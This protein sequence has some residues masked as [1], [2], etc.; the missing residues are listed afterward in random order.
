M[1]SS[2]P[3]P[4]STTCRQL[5]FL[6]GAGTVTGSK[7]LVATNGHRF[8]LDCGLFQGLKELRE[9][10]RAKPSV[11]PAA[12]DA[13]VLSQAHVH[14]SGYLPLLARQGF[15]GPVYCTPPTADLLR[16]MLLDSARLLE[17]EAEAAN[18]LG[19][20]KHQPA[21]PLYTSS[22]AYVALQR[23]AVRRY[24]EPFAV[25]P[26]VSA[27]FRRSAHVL[28]AATVD[29]RLGAGSPTRLVYSGDLG[30]RGRL[31]LRDLEP[32]PEADVL[33][34]EST[35]GDSTHSPSTSEQLAEVI[36]DAGARSG[37]VIVPCSG[38]GR[39][40]ELLWALQSLEDQ[41]RIPRLALFVDSP[42][43]GDLTEIYRR[44]A[45]EHNPGAG[46]ILD[47]MLTEKGYGVVRTVAESKALN[48]RRGPMIIIAGSGMATGGRVLHH[49]KVRLPDARTTVLLAGHQGAGTRGRMLQEG[50]KQIRI[51]GQWVPVH[52]RVVSIEGLSGH[53]DRDEIVAW[54]RGFA[55]APSMTY[56]VHGE[57][58]AAEGLA[59]AIREQLGWSVR[60]AG[61]EE[62]VALESARSARPERALPIG[63]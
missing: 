28:G 54:L 46:K 22:D 39:A 59:R 4:T 3:T 18:R 58:P 1:R 50:V 29:V 23:I 43:A 25:V 21:S 44:H 14:H 6:G 38:V 49:L 13:V 63:Q 55:R 12:I 16:V 27:V 61:H 48:G 34:L 7:Y 15:R 47:A 37:T 10:N 52:A 31:V 45:E 24:H 19:Y 60:V 17:E 26:G 40:Q 35:Y 30:R 32:V 2:P 51:F 56:V 33:L 41:G 11:S 57:P 53:A 62:T 5:S 8:L 42:V 20:S 9:R 36:R